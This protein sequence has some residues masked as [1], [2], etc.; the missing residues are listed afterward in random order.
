MRS[1]SPRPGFDA[2]L[3]LGQLEGPLGHLPRRAR[4]VQTLAGRVEDQ[5]VDPFR[6]GRQHSASAAGSRSAPSPGFLPALFPESPSFLSSPAAAA[7]QSPAAAPSDLAASLLID[8]ISLIPANLIGVIKAIIGVP[9]GGIVSS[10][11]SPAAPTAGPSGRP[12]PARAHRRPPS[13][14]PQYTGPTCPFR[15]QNRVAVRRPHSDRA[16]AAGGEEA[17]AVG[18]SMPRCE[19]LPRWPFSTWMDRFSPGP[20]CAPCRRS[21]ALAACFAPGW[22]AT[23]QTSSLLSG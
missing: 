2:L 7:Q 1:R 9:G 5:I 11:S 12:P 4:S 3:V 22:K 14:L 13:S 15:T 20:R 18:G 6:C 23:A 19:P 17:A 8:W 16:V 10:A 21:P